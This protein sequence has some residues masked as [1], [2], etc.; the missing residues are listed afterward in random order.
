MASKEK[1]EC[2]RCL[3][4]GFPNTMVYLAGKDKQ[5]KTI[6]VEMDG[7]GHTHKTSQQPKSPQMRSQQQH[8]QQQLSPDPP[9]PMPLLRLM[10]AKMDRIIAL[11]SKPDSAENNV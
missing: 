8:Q 6:Y 9:S 4:N 1:Y 11:L 5:G 3:D 2:F 10:D 7:T